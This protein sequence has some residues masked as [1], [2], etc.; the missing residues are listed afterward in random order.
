MSLSLSGLFSLLICPGPG[1]R[2]QAGWSVQLGSR[3]KN[4]QGSENVVNKWQQ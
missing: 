2:G 1:G 3:S 4:P